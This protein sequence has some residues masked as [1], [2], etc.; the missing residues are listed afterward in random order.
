VATI[1]DRAYQTAKKILKEN[2]D[3]LHALTDLLIEKETVLGPELDNLIAEFRPD[4]DF[5]GKKNEYTKPAQPAQT[6][7][8]DEADVKLQENDNQSQETSDDDSDPKTD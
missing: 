8:T 1:I 4:F 5:F 3:I 2:M 6:E 7:K